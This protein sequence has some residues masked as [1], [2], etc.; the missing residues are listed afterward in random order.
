MREY[1]WGYQTV[2]LWGGAG[3]TLM[4]GAQ[5]GLGDVGK[6]K[7]QWRTWRPSEAD[8]LRLANNDLVFCQILLECDPLVVLSG[9]SIGGDICSKSARNKIAGRQAGC[10]PARRGRCTWWKE[11]AGAHCS[12]EGALEIVLK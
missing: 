7:R 3:R 4:G 10:A 2:S 9:N 8:V 1:R 5:G 11:A 12:L 6:G